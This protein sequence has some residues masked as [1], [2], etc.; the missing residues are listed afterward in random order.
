MQQHHRQAGCTHRLRLPVTVAKHA[1]AICRIDQNGFFFCLKLERRPRQKV[2]N[3]G[4]Q[5]PTSQA[6]ARNKLR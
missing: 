2:P 3:Y 1:A 6:C 4:L 5:M